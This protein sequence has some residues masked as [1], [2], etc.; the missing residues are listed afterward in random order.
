MN[1]LQRFRL[2][3]AAPLL[4]LLA[5]CGGGEKLDARVLELSVTYS[6]GGPVAAEMSGDPGAATSGTTVE[7]R[8]TGEDKPVVGEAVANEFG[9]FEMTLDHTEFPQRLPSA[10]EYTTYND[11]IE[12]RPK[13]GSWENPL[14]QPVIRVN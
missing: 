4:L 8:L 5:A 9:A 2:Q 3:H 13:G 12:C 11:T 10:D 1:L 6:A 7:C 14:R